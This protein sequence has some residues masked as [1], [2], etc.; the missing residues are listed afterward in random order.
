MKGNKHRAAKPLRSQTK[1]ILF[2]IAVGVLISILLT[3]GTSTLVLRGSLAEKNTVSAVFI[4]RV[5]SALAASLTAG[6]I[7]KEKHLFVTG[8][9]TLGMFAILIGLGIVLYNGS[10]QNFFVGLLSVL[11]GGGVALLILQRPKRKRY[12]TAKYGQ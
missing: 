4:I 1:A 2:G 10:F 6:A 11:L 8:L 3:A 5:V 12:T 9:T 7:S